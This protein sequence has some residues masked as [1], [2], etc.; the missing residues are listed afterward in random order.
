MNQTLFGLIV[1]HQNGREVLIRAGTDPVHQS[2]G[3][4]HIS[5]DF[6]VKIRVCTTFCGTVKIYRQGKGLIKTGM[7]I[8]VIVVIPGLAAE[9]NTAQLNAQLL[10]ADSSAGLI[11][12]GTA[13]L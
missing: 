3:V 11:F 13:A 12:K 7:L 1:T 8:M 5:I 6:N 10:D 9:G 2:A 4:C